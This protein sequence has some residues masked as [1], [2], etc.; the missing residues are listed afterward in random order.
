LL[1][2]ADPYFANID[3]NQGNLAYLS[4]DLRMF[5]GTPGLNA[6]PIPGGPQLGDSVPGAFQYIQDLLKY[7][8]T[9]FSNPNGID[10]FASGVFPSQGDAGQADSS[11]TPFT[12]LFPFQIFNNYNFAVARV[13]LRGSSGVTGEAKDV[14]VF[15]RLWTTQSNDTDYDTNSTYP[16]TPDSSGKPGSPLL[17]SG[18]TT[19]PFFATGNL[20]GNTDYN[21]AGPNIQTLVIPN[22]QDDLWWYYGCFLNLYDANNKING[23]QVQTLLNGTHHCLVAQI[24]FDDAPIPQGVS[25]LSWDQLAQRNLQITLSD[26]PGPASTHR[27][28]Q[29]FD[30]RPSKVVVPPGGGQEVFPD[31]LMI[32]WGAIPAGSVASLYWP[33]VLASDVIALADQFY[34][35]NS[36][37]AS[38]THTIQVKVTGGITYIPIPSGAGQNFAGL[39]TVDLP[40][41]VAAGEQ[42]NIVVRR[43]STYSVQPPP[44]IQTPVVTHTMPSSLDEKGQIKAAPPAKVEA[45][46]PAKALAVAAP[47]LI[48][49]RYVVGTFQVQIPV[50]TGD[51]ILPSEENTLAIMKWRLQQMAPTNRWYPALLRYISYLAARVDGLGGDSNSILPS[52]NGVPPQQIHP[53]RVYTGRVSEVFFD[54]FGD[55]E[56]FALDDCKGAHPFK[57][58]QQDIGEIALRACKERLLLS[59]YVECGDECRIC[60]LVIR[61]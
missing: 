19:I 25:P 44:Q 10:P 46:S 35:S 8:N 39:F 43:I 56:G 6:T 55:F 16:F 33:Q 23:A 3:P 27:I 28:P 54:C 4:Q 34:S 17:G 45:V 32:D 61:C 47:A 49:W 59:V 15:F 26:N 13:R 2:G 20:S 60:R 37:A 53:E 14:R 58:R 57:T 31:E 18:N 38:D 22:H 36:L 40:T 51:K 7:L 24:A 42:F 48:S 12:F 29:T 9:N 1:A 50:A 52:P 11:V 21:A 5:T 30:C 41:T